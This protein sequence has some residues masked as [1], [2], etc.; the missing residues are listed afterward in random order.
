MP[1]RPKFR[2][3]VS[4]VTAPRGEQHGEIVAVDAASAVQIGGAGA[5]AGSPGLEHG[6]QVGTVTVTLPGMDENCACNECPYMRLNTLEKVYLCMRDRR[7]EITIA[8]D[9]R[10]KCLAPMRRMLE[11][12]A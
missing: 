12:S 2:T 8:E 7:P 6:T 9:L 3:H 11:M 1:L 10:L 5:C 4:A